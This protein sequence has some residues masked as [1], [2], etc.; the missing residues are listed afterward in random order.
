[1]LPLRYARVKHYKLNTSKATWLEEK[2]QPE[3]K[4]MVTSIG[5]YF[6]T[7]AHPSPLHTYTP[8]FSVPP[9]SPRLQGSKAPK[10]PPPSSSWFVPFR[11][12]LKAGVLFAYFTPFGLLP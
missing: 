11:W 2:F 9:S 4:Q 1:M 10:L 8:S 6:G 12:G 3:A 7:H 5:E